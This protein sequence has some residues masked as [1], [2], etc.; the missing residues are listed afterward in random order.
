[1]ATKSFFRGNNPEAEV[2]AE[3]AELR[4]RIELQ[5]TAIQVLR[6]ETVEPSKNS[7]RS[8][9]RSSRRDLLKLAGAGVIGAAGSLVAGSSPV[10]A[11]D[12]DAITAGNTTTATSETKLSATGG[13]FTEGTAFMV[14]ASGASGD[15]DGI[16]GKASGV[17]TGVHGYGGAYGVFGQGGTAAGV[18]GDGVNSA[19]GLI[20]NGGASSGT[21]VSAN[22]GS[23]NGSGVVATGAGTAD[24]VQGTG[25]PTHGIGVHG[26]GGSESGG[27]VGVGVQG[28]GGPG[29]N[30]V[31][32]SGNG[33]GGGPGVSGLGGPSS[34]PGVQGQGGASSGLGVNAFGGSPNGIGVFGTGTGTGGGIFGSGGSSGG[35]GVGGH[36][37][38]SSGVGV[39]GTG[40]GTGA[41]VLGSGGGTSAPGVQGYGG[42]AGGLGLSGLGGSI[43]G[44]GPAGNGLAATGGTNSG[45][46]PAGHGL[47][48]QS[49]GPGGLGGA[50]IATGGRAPIQLGPAAS[51]GTPSQQN[52]KGDVWVDST[53]TAY[54]CIAD[55]NPATWARLGA[56]NP[57]FGSQA[58]TGGVMNLL[59]N[60]IRIL[61][62]R[63]ASPYGGGSTHSL[64][65]TG[66]ADLNGTSTKVPSGA[67]AVIGNVTAVFP[68]GSGDLRLFPHGGTL[69]T[70]SNLNYN[71]NT[72]VANA[73]IIG[74]STAGAL[75]VFV[76]VSTTHVLFDCSGFVI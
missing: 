47:V 21:G 39:T 30:G 46:G 72:T 51:P 41:G 33:V 37:G 20:G 59:P 1:M 61:D 11:A 19:P 62:T 4:A 63:S 56:V 5:E 70:T 7:R 60:P 73:C 14:D 40:A 15:N 9:D 6:S 65:V 17:D 50:F 12:G 44:A 38:G 66:T 42:A 26:F 75:D 28:D 16:G 18:R 13:P 2:Q 53:G 43:S 22:G 27:F 68:Q 54:L 74:L 29:P 23:P 25:G 48:A 55:G 34:G 49:G 67:V 52:Y 36:G 31:G 32:V 64:Q 3:L 8:R 24:G 71:L 69:P 58:N 45:A 10:L 57:R 35:Y 76:D